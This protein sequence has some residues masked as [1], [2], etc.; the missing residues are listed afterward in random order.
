MT[1]PPQNAPHYFVKDNCLYESG[2]N[3]QGAYTKLLCNFAP[4]A[5]REIIVDNGANQTRYVQ[6]GGVHQSGRILPEITILAEDVEG[7]GWIVKNWGMDCILQPGQRTRWSI[8]NA[9]Q[10]SA[11]NMETVTFFSTTGWKKIAEDWHY[12]MP[13]DDQY[14]VELDGKMH[15]YG[16]ERRYEML[17][18]QIAASLLWQPLAPEEIML[19]LLSFTFLSP[20]NHFLKS[21]GCEPKFVMLLSGKTGSRKST[22]AALFLSGLC[23]YHPQGF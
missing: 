20:L 14:T 8:W 6:L 3:K 10:T 17:D 11:L 23:G 4:R 22:L 5:I 12:L 2:T 18:I 7:L 13:G 1:Q 21:A 16:M 19:P 9:L 15:G